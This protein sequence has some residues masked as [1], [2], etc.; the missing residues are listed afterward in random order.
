[1]KPLLFA[2]TTLY[3]LLSTTAAQ[4]DHDCKDPV[5]D[6]QP[7][8]ALRKQLET[9]GWEVRRIKIDDGC[10]EV[11]GRDQHGNKVEADYFPGSLRLRKLEIEFHEDAVI[12][13]GLYSG[14]DDREDTR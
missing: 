6:W 9:R 4:A 3:A 12:P 1:M 2:A 7:R 10:Y 11:K 8:D 5:S 13:E 14:D